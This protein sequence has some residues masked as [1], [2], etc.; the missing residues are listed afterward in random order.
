[1]VSKKYR[2]FEAIVK[3]MSLFFGIWNLDFFRSLNN[4]CL[5]TDTFQTLA[6]DLAVSFYPLL[7]ILLT[8]FLIHLYDRKFR[9][10]VV[11]WEPFR[12]VLQFF[13]K[14]W[15]IKTSL[16]DSSATF[17]FLSNVKILSVSFDLLVPVQVFQL[18]STGHLSTSWRLYYDATIPYFGER[19]LPYA[20]LAIAVLTIFVL[21]PVLLM[22][23]YPFGW[24]HK[25]LNLF[26]FRWYIL[27]T[28]VDTFY[29]CY[30][31]GT[32]PNTRDC[33]WFAS[34]FFLCRIFLLVIAMNIFNSMYYPFFLMILTLYV[35]LQITVQPFKEGYFS[36]VNA[37]F[38]LLLALWHASIIGMELSTLSMSKT[39]LYLFGSVAFLV[40]CI[41]LGFLSFLILRWMYSHKKFGT[42]YFL[43]WRHGYELIK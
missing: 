5:Q 23:L 7:L 39:L 9:L 10:L 33:R 24:F 20:I 11:I 3:W 17:F 35:C 16:I 22:I 2:H 6:L 30:K 25:V 8:Y 14:N 40:N 19:H 41:F 31:D 29:G 36:E 37:V 26:P 28:F 43:C 13:H 42:K 32:E 1:M 15:E 21:L 18:N 34:V 12:K 38:M 4:I 27:H